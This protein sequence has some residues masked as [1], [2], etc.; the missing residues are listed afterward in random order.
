MEAIM[1][2]SRQDLKDGLSALA[3]K[4]DELIARDDALIAAVQALIAK[5][6]TT[7]TEDFAEELTLVSSLLQKDSD[8]STKV[9]A[10]TDAT[11]SAT[12]A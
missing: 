4:Q 2:A 3:A 9:Q 10:A 11:T 7:G 8:E 12:P 6:P 1:A 5:L